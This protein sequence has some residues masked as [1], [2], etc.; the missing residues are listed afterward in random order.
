VCSLVV[1]PLEVPRQVLVGWL[2]WL[3]L[4]ELSIVLTV[5][6]QFRIVG[7]VERGYQRRLEARLS[8][9]CMLAPLALQHGPAVFHRSLPPALSGL[10]AA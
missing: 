4:R 3:W 7:K 10:V 9:F 5:I 2:V 8:P 6:E 1:R